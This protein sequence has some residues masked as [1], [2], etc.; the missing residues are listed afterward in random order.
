M[1]KK[2]TGI[3]LHTT[4]FS[5]ELITFLVVS[6]SLALSSWAYLI[7]GQWFWFI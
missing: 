6:G 3:I 1:N 7:R 5:L 4:M 2:V